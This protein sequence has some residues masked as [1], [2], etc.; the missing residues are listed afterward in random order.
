[1]ANV[2]MRDIAEKLGV[3]I[4]SVSKALTGK[5]GVS[6]ELREKVKKGSR[7]AWISL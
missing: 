7:Q 2:T 1:M 6:E 4:V 5:E 3:S